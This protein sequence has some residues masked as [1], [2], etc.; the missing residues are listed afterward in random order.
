MDD[1]RTLARE[2][3]DVAR[4]PPHEAALS[5]SFDFVLTLVARDYETELRD[6]LRELSTAP[7][8]GAC[9]YLSRS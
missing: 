5:V 6:A 3:V 2:L 9:P 1:A 8:E 7:V 4:K